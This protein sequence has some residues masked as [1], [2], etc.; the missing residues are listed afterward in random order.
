MAL[1]RGEL[2][3]QDL[4][5]E[6]GLARGGGGHNRGG[7]GAG[8]GG[9][10]FNHGTLVLDNVRLRDNCAIGGDGG[11]DL[12][13]VEG[14]ARGGGGGMGEA[15]TGGQGGGFGGAFRDRPV[16]SHGLFSGGGGSGFGPRQPGG[17]ALAPTDSE[18]NGIP[19]AGGPGGGDGGAS[20][21]FP[22]NLSGAHHGGGPGQG[23]L[24]GAGG[25]VG[26]GG[27]P[28]SRSGLLGHGAGAGSFGGGGGG[29]GAPGGFGGGHGG[30]FGR[31]R[32]GAGDGGEGLGGAVCNHLGLVVLRDALI[33]DNL[34]QGGQGGGAGD[35]LGGIQRGRG[36]AARGGGLFSL[37]GTVE[38]R[39]SRLLDNR[40]RPGPAGENLGDAGEDPPPAAVDGDDCT[41]QGARFQVDNDSL[42]GGDGGDGCP[43]L[44]LRDTN[45]RIVTITPVDV[46]AGEPLRV[47]FQVDSAGIPAS[48]RVSVISSVPEV[49]CSATVAAG[50]CTLVFPAPGEYQ[51][52]ARMLPGGS[53]SGSVSDPEM[54]TVAES[55]LIFRDGFDTR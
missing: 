26:G 12:F 17:D 55:P 16:A 3:L 54:L 49:G 25:G 31:E 19:G 37:D 21:V 52:Q 11:D 40:A 7:G 45:T 23:G 18:F 15:G 50:A 4:W 43:M 35:L 10:V 36:G 32:P 53:F 24:P 48:G 6:Q 1:P 13:G 9:A 47:A 34:A 44:F 29:L 51:V 27:G 41:L 14:D 33:T 28:G 38:L 5:L 8:M 22:E 46:A 30:G 20:P 39:R 42:V 2:H